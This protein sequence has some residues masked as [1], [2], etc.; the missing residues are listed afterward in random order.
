M[1]VDNHILKSFGN[2]CLYKMLN[3]KLLMISEK[4]FDRNYTELV[5]RKCLECGR[6]SDTEARRST[7]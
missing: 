3:D 7:E 2:C 1:Y 5:F 6:Q 4:G